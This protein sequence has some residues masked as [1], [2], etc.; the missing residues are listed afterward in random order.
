MGGYWLVGQYQQYIIKKEMEARIK[1]SPFSHETEQFVFA[2]KNGNPVEESFY[3]EDED[4]F[5][6]RDNMYDVIS[7][8]IVDGKLYI[9]CFND[10]KEEGLIE[11][12]IDITKKENNK[13]GNTSPTVQLIL[14][15]VFVTPENYFLPSFNTTNHLPVSVYQFRLLNRSGD[16]FIPPPQ[17]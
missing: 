15:L 17:A 6:Y 14:S 2:L 13:P 5:H 1:T 10:S 16:I 9:T 3:W 4:E 11:H 7:K 12:Y 8:K